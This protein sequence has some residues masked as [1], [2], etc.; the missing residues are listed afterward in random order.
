M[1]QFLLIFLIIASLLIPL[2]IGTP[3][4]NFLKSISVKQ[5]IREDGPKEHIYKKS[6]T[7][8]IGGL[9]FLMPLFLICFCLCYFKKEFRSL[10]LFIVLGSTSIMAA[11]G[12]IDDYLKVIKKQNKGIS[13][14][15]KLFIQ[16]LISLVI[17]CF[18]RENGGLI[19]LL[20]IFFIFSGSSNSYNLTDGLDGLLASISIVSF[21]GLAVLFHQLGNINLTIFSL[22]FSSV[23]LGFL[24]FNKH[25]AKVFMGDTGSLAIGGA[26]GALAIV[27][28]HELFLAF[29]ATI[30]ILEAISVILQVLSC[31]LSK[32]FLGVDKRIF[33]MTPL[34]HHFELV[35][36][37]E[38]DIVKRFFMFQVVCAI[39]GIFIILI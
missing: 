23:L 14:W 6:D 33:K 29:F 4:I 11:L 38:N 13:G 17:Y 28:R 3:L 1:N 22:M 30:P 27:S 18:Y 25:P 7:P 12:F 20:W 5:T 34:H 36:W 8:T 31:Q 16:L 35:G 32:R 24:Y 39:A 15:S 10:D 9:I 19:Y 21:L 26:V 2:I 37:K